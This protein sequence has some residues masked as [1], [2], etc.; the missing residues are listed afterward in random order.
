MCQALHMLV[1]KL[2][3]ETTQY[4]ATFFC[5]KTTP[6]HWQTT[7]RF[8]HCKLLYTYTDKP[9][10][11]HTDLCGSTMNTQ[12]RMP[13]SNN[14]CT[15]YMWD[16]TLL[17]FIFFSVNRW[18]SWNSEKGKGDRRTCR[19]QQ[20]AWCL[21]NQRKI[22]SHW[23]CAVWMCKKKIASLSL[24]FWYHPERVPMPCFSFRAIP[25]VESVNYGRKTVI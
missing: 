20:T 6:Q 19:A 2:F 15:V 21:E 14:I 4:T 3:T 13:Q 25:T 1:G 5:T 7:V 18:N 8:S 23:E 12:K 10:W 16:K 22:E 9:L 11:F 24:E 17:W